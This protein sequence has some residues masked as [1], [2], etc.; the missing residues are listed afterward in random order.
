M[1][2]AEIQSHEDLNLN[3]CDPQ[4]QGADPMDGTNKF[5]YMSDQIIKKKK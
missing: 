3:P 2:T 1:D 5:P 4:T